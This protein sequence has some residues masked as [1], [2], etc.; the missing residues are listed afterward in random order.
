MKQHEFDDDNE[1]PTV[2]FFINPQ[3]KA[4]TKTMPIKSQV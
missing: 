2:S 3:G 1:N 4:I